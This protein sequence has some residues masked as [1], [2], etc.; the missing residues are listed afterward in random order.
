M[1]TCTKCGKLNYEGVQLCTACGSPLPK[2][3]FVNE[4]I[5]DEYEEDVRVESP[6]AEESEE[7]DNQDPT[8]DSDSKKKII[9]FSIAGVLIVGIVLLIIFWPFGSKSIQLNFGIKDPTNNQLLKIDTVIAGQE[10]VFEDKTEG[11]KN[12]LWSSNELEDFESENPINTYKFNDIGTFWIK[13]TVNNKF[14]DSVKVIVTEGGEETIQKPEVKIEGEYLVNKP[15]KFIDLTTDAKESTWFLPTEVNPL[16]GKEVEYTFKKEGEYE[17]SLKNEKTEAN[18]VRKIVISGNAPIDIKKKEEEK[19]RIEEAKR[20]AEEERKR[21]LLE[22]KDKK[23]QDKI[24]SEEKKRQEAERKKEQD[25]IKKN[26][27]NN[28]SLADLLQKCL[29]ETNTDKLFEVDKK[30]KNKEGNRPRINGKDAWD[31]LT[32]DLQMGSK[33]KKVT[34]TNAEKSPSGGYKSITVEIK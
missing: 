28:K 26:N 6:K 3:D 10:L 21:K 15:M 29:G 32:S 1:A 16:K 22:G 4:E 25:E 31:F 11:V 18:L 12:R 19:K 20:K 33:N 23:E 14:T 13:L 34:V 24:L 7:T 17:I 2:N 5:E 27:L 8:I 30:L 9:K